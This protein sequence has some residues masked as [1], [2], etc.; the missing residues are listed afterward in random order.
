[1][2]PLLITL[3][4]L[5]S[6]QLASAQDRLER[7][8]ALKYAALVSADAS[9]LQNT[10]IPTSVD[11]KQPVALQDGEYGS[12]VLPQAKLSLESL[13]KAGELA[14]PV[15]QLW[16][17]K[18]TP[19]RDGSRIEAD[20]LRLASVRHDGET[21]T[22]PQCALAVR[23]N[24]GALQLLVF[25]KGKEPVLKLPLKEIKA[26]QEAP[27]DISAERIGDEGRIT[28]RILGKYEAKLTVTELQL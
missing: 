11:L 1:M 22:V 21:T 12:M 14:V 28:L 24:A 3:T 4:V 26:D 10:P 16:L 8:D 2:K 19:V 7:D 18:L 25:G 20:E 13:A 9:Q 27:I 17:L 5:T 23:R 6:L 15:G